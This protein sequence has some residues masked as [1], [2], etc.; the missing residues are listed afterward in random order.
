MPIIEVLLA[1]CYILIGCILS[2]PYNYLAGGGMNSFMLSAVIAPVG[3]VVLFI[4]HTVERVMARNEHSQARLRGGW[5]FWGVVT[6]LC[7]PIIFNGVSLLLNS[8]GFGKVGYYVHEFRYAALLLVPLLL[9]TICF[10]MM[11]VK[12]I[13]GKFKVNAKPP[14]ST[15]PGDIGTGREGCAQEEKGKDRDIGPYTLQTSTV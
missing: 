14:S 9:I 2:V 5:F 12:S 15:P 13:L 11:G 3:A 7:L 4:A 6:Y 10:V 8:M 1:L